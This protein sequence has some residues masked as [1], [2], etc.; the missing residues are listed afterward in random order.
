MTL[1]EVHLC[2]QYISVRIHNNYARQAALHGAKMRPKTVGRG[3]LHRAPVT[4][5]SEKEDEL[6]ERA[7]REALMK[8]RINQKFLKEA[9]KKLK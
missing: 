3:I 1:R 5:F 9:K 7:M 8:Q 6:A 2:L 4:E